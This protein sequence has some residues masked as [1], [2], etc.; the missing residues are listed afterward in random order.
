MRILFVIGHYLPDGGPSAP[1]FGMLCERL[2]RRG[3]EVT[4]LSTVPHYPTGRVPPEYK[5]RLVRRSRENG[6][7]VIRIWVPSVDRARLPRRLAQFVS[8]QFGAVC[9]AF[10]LKPDVVLAATPALAVWL[11][12]FFLARTRKMPAVYSVHDVY[13]EVGVK[14]GIFRNPAVIRFISCLERS[15]FSAAAKVRVLSESFMPAAKRLGVPAE[16]LRL[17]YDWV[18]TELIRPLPRNN[19]FSAEQGLDGSF[20]VLY[21]GNMGLTHGLGTVVD[22][23]AI[24]K[25]QTGIQFVFVGEGGGKDLAQARARDL[26]LTN[27][28]FLPFQP[29]ALLPEVLATADVS[30]VTLQKGFG[31]DSLPSKIFS[32]LASGRPVIAGIDPDSDAWNLVQRSG[33]GLCVQP[34]DPRALADAVQKLAMDPGL[35]RAFGVRGRAYVLAHHSPDA[36]TQAFEHLFEDIMSHSRNSPEHHCPEEMGHAK[37]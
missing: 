17:V 8:Y 19:A 37:I 21:A 18:D 1:L 7:T 25:A 31:Y 22:A 4:V 10:S 20:V 9:A 6:V 27:V 36:A 5:G 29:R 28:R 15:C 23:A 26:E 30:L 3:H 13:P 24:L 11:P 14:L 12:F 34:D 32:I 2:A 35:G 33:A 16:K